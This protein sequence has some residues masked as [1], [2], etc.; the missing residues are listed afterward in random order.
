[1]GLRLTVRQAL[2]SN[3]QASSLLVPLRLFGVGPALASRNQ[4]AQTAVYI[5]APCVGA[6]IE[7]LI[8][9]NEALAGETDFRLVAVCG[10]FKHNSR[11]R[12]FG[13]ILSDFAILNWTLSML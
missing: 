6:Y 2:P 7:T 1:M 8:R 11:V 4:A 3:E 12:P 10:D 9:G 13:P 5:G